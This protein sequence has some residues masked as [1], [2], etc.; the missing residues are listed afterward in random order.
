M[1]LK[2]KEYKKIM[3]KFIKEHKNKI[4]EKIDKLKSNNPREFQKI[5]NDNKR[6]T[7]SSN[8]DITTLVDYFKGLN[9]TDYGEGEFP[10]VKLNENE[11]VNNII[12]SEITES[13][14]M[15]ANTKLK[16]K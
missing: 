9:E 6:K 14:I 11:F 5:I 8:I 3:N 2:A 12:N 7:C 1:N 16:K 15:K 4:K 13:E 10:H